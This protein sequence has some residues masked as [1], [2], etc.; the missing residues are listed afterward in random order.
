MRLHIAL[1]PLLLWSGAA[2]A[3]SQWFAFRDP[4]G[5]FTAD[6]PGTP[7]VG[8]DSV[9]GDDGKPVPMLE[10]TIDHG[11]SAMVLIVSDLSRFP[12]ADSGK[13]IDGAVGGVKGT[14]TKVLSDTI[15]QLD[16]QI[17]REVVIVDK[18]GNQ[19]VDRIFFVAHKLYQVM[20]V[21]S[22]AP[23]PAE[24]V[25]ARHFQSGFHFTGN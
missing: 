4:A 21:V 22:K 12:D 19:I 9:K 13:V 6:V 8:Q 14:A 5:A 15:S 11:D 16:N 20:T 3:D 2:S 17:G 23:T 25:D 10:Y 7:T 24:L 18:D 1:L